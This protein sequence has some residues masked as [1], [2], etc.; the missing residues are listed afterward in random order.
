M[1]KII[2]KKFSQLSTQELYDILQL[3]SVVFVVEQKCIYQ[4]MDGKDQKALHILGIK[5][6]KL[7]AYTRIFKPDDYF[8]YASIG[9]VVVDKNQRQHKYGYDIMHASI[10]AIKQY[11]KQTTIKI[12][13]QAY[14]KGFYNNLGFKQVGESYLEDGIPHVAMIR[15]SSIT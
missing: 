8:E 13:A 10:D 2:I 9:R 7:V 4:D 6:D 5:D 3:R 14:L 15:N 11:F 12:S 1:L